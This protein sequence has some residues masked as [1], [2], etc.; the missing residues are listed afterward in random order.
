MGKLMGFIRK[1]FAEMNDTL[2]NTLNELSKMVDDVEEVKDDAR[3]LR[4]ELD[5]VHR[6]S[7][8]MMSN[9]DIIINNEWMDYP[10]VEP[11]SHNEYIVTTECGNVEMR[12]FLKD[13]GRWDG[14]KKKRN[15]VIAWMPKPPP[16]SKR[17]D[18]SNIFVE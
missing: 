5:D 9:R 4:K 13:V 7:I 1:C 15:Q 16:S 2:N 11:P 18:V 14:G 6:L 10:E 3:M 8:D 17:K 12:T